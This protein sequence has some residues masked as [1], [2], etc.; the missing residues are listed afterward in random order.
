MNQNNT[1]PC[2]SCGLCCQNIS[3]IEELKDYDIGNGICKYF[4]VLNNEC[5]IYETRPD[6]CRIDKMF[7]LEYKKYFTKE[8]FYIEN[9]KVCNSLQK[10]Y[11]LDK[12]FKIN[13]IGE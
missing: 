13:I 9:A 4:D 2:T 1:F 11:G 3:K 10:K 8:A 12:S 5:Q 6:I 7:G